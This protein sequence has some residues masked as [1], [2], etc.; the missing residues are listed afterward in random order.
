M[1]DPL[2]SKSVSVNYGDRQVVYTM[3]N[4]GF[5][6]AID[7]TKPASHT[8]V[9]NT[10][11][12]EL[13]AFMPESLLDN[14]PAI[15]NNE[16]GDQHIYGLDGSLTRWHDDTDSDGIVDDDEDVTLF[17]GMRRGGTEYFALDVSDELAPV[18][19]WRINQDTPGFERLAQSWSRMS[20]INVTHDS[21]EKLVLAFAAGYD[22]DVQ[23][24]IDEPVRSKGNAI[25]MVDLAGTRLWTVDE[26]SHSDLLYSIP[27][28]LTLI[29]SDG[30]QLADRLYV[31]DVAGQLWRV[32]FGDINETPTVTKLA[33]LADASHQPFF[34]P[35]SIALNGESGDRFLSVTIGSGNRTNP[36][37]KPVQNNFYMIRDNDVAKGPPATSFTTVTVDDLYDATDNTVQSADA[38]IAQTAQAELDA[39]R[40]WRVRLASGEKA[41]STVL[42]YAG[43]VLATTYTP[44]I[45][46]TTNICLAESSGTFYSMN[47]TD[48]T[49]SLGST[50]DTVTTPMAA[51]RTQSVNTQGIPS[52]PVPVL[53]PDS[54]TTQIFVGKEAVDSIP[55]T[56]SRIYWHGR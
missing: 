10:G 54:N 34:Y 6:H 37:L 48:A 28:D 42:T 38:T 40:G 29:D 26:T 52:A 11:G 14:L 56:L 16:F 19:K 3:T 35:P 53:T 21:D 18:L 33:N 51:D 36:L 4:Q 32:D 9:D 7:A 23:D 8:V 20:I 17:F 30:D 31:G 41:L 2:H 45:N 39:A 15:Y 24:D 43:Q 50:A 5:L 44:D 47:V 55:R 25:Y 13:F 49:P 12:E 27:S 22:A 46:T 1:G